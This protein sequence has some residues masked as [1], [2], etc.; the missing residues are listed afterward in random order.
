MQKILY[1]DADGELAE[2]VREVLHLFGWEV[3]HIAEADENAEVVWEDY[4]LLIIDWMVPGGVFALSEKVFA[5]GYS[6]KI[7][8]VSAREVSN[9]ARLKMEQ[10]G[11]KYMSKPFSVI[12]LSDAVERALS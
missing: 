4:R 2:V 10:R 5:R 3:E 12:A 7:M 9:S 8:V 6:G 11:L 1:V